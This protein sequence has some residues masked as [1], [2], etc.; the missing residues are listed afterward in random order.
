GYVVAPDAVIMD[1]LL[2]ISIVGKIATVKRILYL[3]VIEKGE[4]TKLPFVHYHK[5]EKII[6]ECTHT[7][8]A[9]ADGEFFEAQ[10]FEIICLTKRFR[11]I[12]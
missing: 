3:P 7:V 12:W 1:S 10:T 5:S 2:D 9:H 11:F 6:I 8:P 4:H